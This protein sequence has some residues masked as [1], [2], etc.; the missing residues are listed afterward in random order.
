[1]VV[2]ER[3]PLPRSKVCGDGLT[4]RSV[5]VLNDLGITDKSE[6]YHSVRGLRVFG[7]DR[8]MELDWPKL[9]NFPDYGLVRPRK[10]LDADIAA[11]ARAAGAEIRERT[12]VVAPVLE[13]GRLT[14]VRWVRK[15]NAEG[16]G[17][18]KVD[19]GVISA[20]L[21]IIADGA[22]S[23]FGRTLGITR[24]PA[25]PVGL[26]IRTYY[27]SPMHDDDFIESWLELRKDG[28]LLPGY[29]WVFP[30]GDGTV[31]VGVGLLSSSGKAHN[32]NL[33]RLQRDFVEVLPPSYGITHEGQTEPYKSGRLHLG[34]SVTKPY[35]NG[36]MLI[37]DAAGVI[38]P[39]NGEGIAYALETGKIAA[40]IAA[41]ALSDGCSTDL[42][43]YRV[44][45]HDI[46]GGYFRL[47]L[48]F[49]KLITKPKVFRA[50]CQVGMRSETVMAF[51]L[52][53]LANLAEDH[54]GRVA[55]RAFRSFIVLAEKEISDLA[56]PEIP[57]PKGVRAA[58]AQPDRK[59]V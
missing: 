5:K 54:G 17:V 23:S 4:P 51:A 10:H 28:L 57:M 37:G 43:E 16:G 48:L 32:V 22:G 49:S 30:V 42:A 31:N 38:N 59:A 8:V 21:T 20:P 47:G 15:E 45:L 56:D 58:A 39:F 25:H 36:Y 41:E 53:F 1:V 3:K 50:M 29:G 44:A 2:L 35:G 55:D 9:S 34:Q 12:E 11:R 26:G 27:K 14:G 19:E 40:G 33:N 7:A 52:Q 13:D 46:Y 6:N 24:N 18:V